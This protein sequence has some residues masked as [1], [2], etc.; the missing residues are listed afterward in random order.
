MRNTTD[1]ETF[2]V[3]QAF[4]REHGIPPTVRELAKALG[5]SSTAAHYRLTRLREHGLVEW[6]EGKSRTLRIVVT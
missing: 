6:E 2:A 3:L 5:I 4:I 1:T